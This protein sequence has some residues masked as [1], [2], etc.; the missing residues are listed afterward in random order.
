MGVEIER[1]FVVSELPKQSYRRIS[2]IA[3]GYLNADPART[4]RIRIEDD[5][6]FLTLKG[7]NEG[8]KR[9]EIETALDVKVARQMLEVLPNTERIEKKRHYVEYEGMEWTLDVFGGSLKGLILAE[10]ELEHEAQPIV[11]PDWID[12]KKEVSL[13]MRFTNVHLMACKDVAALLDSLSEHRVNTSVKPKSR[14]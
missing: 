9:L 3:Q 12:P 6:G 5:K 13:D 8:L 2:S 1:K 10:V 7:P 11:L 4:V 14:S